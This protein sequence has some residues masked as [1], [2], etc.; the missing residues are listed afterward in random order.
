MPSKAIML[1]RK[2]INRKLLILVSLNRAFR[3]DP[4]FENLFCRCRNTG[5]VWVRDGGGGCYCYAIFAISY[6][7]NRLH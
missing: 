4:F 3:K 5:K 2:G 1:T 6:Q 7:H